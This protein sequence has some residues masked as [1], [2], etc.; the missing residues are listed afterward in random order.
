MWGVAAANICVTPAPA[1]TGFYLPLKMQQFIH[2][3]LP[4]HNFELVWWETHKARLMWDPKQE[5][6]VVRPNT[7]N[8]QYIPIN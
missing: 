3:M 1:G 5:L 4:R 2:F 8:P 7:A 6:Y